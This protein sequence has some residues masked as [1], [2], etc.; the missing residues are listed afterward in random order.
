MTDLILAR[1]ND[2]AVKAIKT[3]STASKFL[4]PS[5]RQSVE[6][7]F[8]RRRDVVLSFDGGF[9]GAER[10][11]AI[12]TNP[13][14]GEYSSTGFLTALKIAYRKQDILGHR[15]ILGSLMGLGIERDTIGD[16]IIAEHITAVVC[17]PELSEYIAENLTKAGRVGIEIS[18]ISLD[19]LPALQ[20]NLTEKT[21]TVASLRLDSILSVA[22]SVSRSK[23]AELIAAG[24]VSL[25]HQICGK[26]PRELHQLRL[27]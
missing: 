27:D 25:N 19:E 14:W 23:A 20:E 2:L 6:R 7:A 21:D 24:I 8:S 22:F 12:F 26:S 3:G 5:E 4:T 16:I 17:L 13:N 9:D 18:Q 15:D 11:R 10:T 1:M